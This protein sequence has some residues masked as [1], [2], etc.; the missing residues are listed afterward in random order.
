MTQPQVETLH[1]GWSWQV[2]TEEIYP[3]PHWEF[4]MKCC[5]RCHKGPLTGVPD[6]DF[7]LCDECDYATETNYERKVA[8]EAIA[9]LQK[10]NEAMLACMH[11][12]GDELVCVDCGDRRFSTKPCSK[13]ETRFCLEC[14]RRHSLF[15][16]GK[17]APW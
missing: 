11:Q 9:S 15:C 7:E 1:F 6:E 8:A 17:A 4:W 5:P 12:P 10:K 3:G 2:W 14:Q 16:K 13:C